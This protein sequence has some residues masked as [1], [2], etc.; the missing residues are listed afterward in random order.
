M[1]IDVDEIIDLLAGDCVPDDAQ[2]AE[3]V[4]VELG[5]ADGDEHE[6]SISPLETEFG[7][8][9]FGLRNSVSK[10]DRAVH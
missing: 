8:Q 7:E 4:D 10:L 5:V 2:Q 9:E 6:G 3:A 1:G